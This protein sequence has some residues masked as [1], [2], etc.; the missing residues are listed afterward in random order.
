MPHHWYSGLY[1]EIFHIPDTIKRIYLLSMLRT[2]IQSVGGIFL[3]LL[4]FKEMG[5]GAVIL[6]ALAYSIGIRLSE[7]FLFFKG[8]AHVER[9]VALGI[10]ISSLG[11]LWGSIT[12]D[13][14]GVFLSGIIVGVGS[15][16]YWLIHHASYVLYGK[17]K[18][19]Q[20]EYSLELVLLNLTSL[21]TPVMVTLLTFF[22]SPAHTLL[23]LSLLL[24]LASFFLPK[25]IGDTKISLE[26]FVK[27]DI[28]VVSP[29]TILF[30]LDGLFMAATFFLPI[31]IYSNG[32]SYH[33]TAF[34]VTIMVMIRI[35][36]DYIIG[37][38][39]ER[40]SIGLAVL[41]LI[42]TSLMLLIM[43]EMPS[44]APILYVI[45]PMQLFSLVYMAWVYEKSQ[46]D[47]SIMMLRETLALS[48]GK[49]SSYFL[50]LFLG[51]KYAPFLGFIFGVLLALDFYFTS[52]L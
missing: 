3:P 43:Y 50:V 23:V 12:E 39:P 6:Y 51:V 35:L 21:F 14:A 40:K 46:E 7:L 10:F 4:F 31:F 36:L 26:R 45:L 25:E 24:F 41:S 44:L 17:K 42:I 15:G 2:I 20:H 18:D 32:V 37:H 29:Y 52:R 49:M 48:I 38:L 13:L 1:S 8:N 47:P 5:I 30:I 19:E 28:N 22:M 11:L 27:A 9:D 34:L 16:F 33:Q